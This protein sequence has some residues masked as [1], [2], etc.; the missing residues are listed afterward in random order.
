M[1]KIIYVGYSESKYRL[2]IILAH[3]RDCHFAN[4]QL[5]TSFINWEATRVISWN[6][7]YIY[8][9]SCALNMFKTIDG[10][11]D[12]K[13]RSV[14]R[15]CTLGMCYQVRFITRSAK[16]MVYRRRPLSMRREYKSLWPATII[17]S[18]MAANMWK[19]SLK[20]VECETGKLWRRVESYHAYVPSSKRTLE[21]AR[22]SLLVTDYNGHTIWAG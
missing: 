3:P 2:R 5:L 7:C 6:S 4:V 11:A 14:I 8:V 16:R 21:N 17:A 1:Y 13:I 22:G 18:I 12:C 10:A 9:C 19:N 20:N 15:F